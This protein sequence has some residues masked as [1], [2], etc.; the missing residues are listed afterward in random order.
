[1]RFAVLDRKYNEPTHHLHQNETSWNQ[2]H[3]TNEGFFATNVT[4]HLGTKAKKLWNWKCLITQFFWGCPVCPLN[5][6]CLFLLGP[7][8]LVGYVSSLKPVCVFLFGPSLQI[9]PTT[10]LETPMYL[11]IF[12]YPFTSTPKCLI[13]DIMT[14]GCLTWWWLERQCSHFVF[15]PSGGSGSCV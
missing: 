4:T 11:N 10:F 12:S 3:W 7:S 2:W 15:L 14:W 6:V 8:W 1:M 9:V 5:L 13:L